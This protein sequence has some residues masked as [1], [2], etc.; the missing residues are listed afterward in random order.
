[1][2]TGYVNFWEMAEDRKT[3]SSGSFSINKNFSLLSK[4]MLYYE[5][6]LN[7]TTLNLDNIKVIRICL[8][9]ELFGYKR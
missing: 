2:N 5:N 4:S 6:A 8:R 9:R 7:F 3:H 1:M